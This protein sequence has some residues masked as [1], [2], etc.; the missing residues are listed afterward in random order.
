MAELLATPILGGLMTAGQGMAGAGTLFGALSNVSSGSSAAGADAYNAQLDQQRSQAALDTANAQATQVAQDNK[1]KMGEVAA[2]IGAS[3]VETT[4]TPLSVMADQAMQGELA[5]Q[6][7]QYQGT[8][9]A[10]AYNAQAQLDEAK[11]KQ[12]ENSG[13]FGAGG[14]LLSGFGK[15]ASQNYT[16]L[17]KAGAPAA[18]AGADSGGVLSTIAGWF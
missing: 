1:R 17:A 2:N 10:N 9:Q 16:P 5:R 4:G 14:T 7:T 13:L 6:L 12:D 11:A 3:G 8:V 18:T 15:L